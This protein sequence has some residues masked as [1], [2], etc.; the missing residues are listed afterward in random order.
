MRDIEAIQSLDTA[1]LALRWALERLRALERETRDAQEAGRRAEAAAAKT[2]TELAAARDLLARRTN[3]ALERE[4][5]GA[6]L[7]EYLSLK[8][9]GQLDPGALVR[10]E[11]ALSR[12]EAEI[13][14]RE[15]ELERRLKASRLES[16]EESRRAAAAVEAAAEL[17]VRQMRDELDSRLSSR[18]KE[19]SARHVALAEREAQLNTLERSLEERSRRLGELFAAQRA[20][21]ERESSALAQAARDQ[22]EML[23]RRVEQAAAAKAAALEGGW[24]AERKALLDELA[25]WRA[26]AREHLP[27]FLAAVRR[28]EEA[29][30]RSERLEYEAGAARRLAEE[31]L[32]ETMSVLQGEDKRREE[33][34]RLE[35]SLAARLLDAEK[36]LFRQYDAWAAREDELRRRDADWRQQAEARRK[37]VD[38]ARAEVLALRDELSRAIADYRLRADND[39]RRP[40]R[41]GES[42]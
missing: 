26:K 2:A 5:Y 38:A 1:R 7:E 15:I 14:T 9:A 23:E 42:A 22:A 41:G 20:A 18:E 39:A 31:R 25:V 36:Q 6:K 29:D 3:E 37:V 11:A 12:A 30:A 32:A 27:G 28:A 34:A 17:R 8:L 35:T 24:Q 13:Q 10:R 33:F 16:E 21:L 4:R 40:P 19:H